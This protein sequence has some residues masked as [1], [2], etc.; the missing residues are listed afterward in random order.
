M[1][2]RYNRD[3][4]GAPHVSRG[5]MAIAGHQVTVVVIHPPTTHDDTA[6]ALLIDAHPVTFEPPQRHRTDVASA[7]AAWIALIDMHLDIG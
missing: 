1:L 4:P 6:Y 7:T 2:F 3:R 5:E